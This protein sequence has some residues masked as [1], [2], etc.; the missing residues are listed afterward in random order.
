MYVII[1]VKRLP[2]YDETWVNPILESNLPD[3]IK[4]QF[5]VSDY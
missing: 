1:G 5:P 2:N 3:F 4:D